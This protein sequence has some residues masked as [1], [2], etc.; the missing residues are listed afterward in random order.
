MPDSNFTLITDQKSIAF[1]LDNRK[2]SKIKNNKIHCWRLELALFSYTIKF[3]P[4]R[5]NDAADAFTHAVC[6]LVNTFTPQE[7]HQNLCH[8]GVRWLAHYVHAKNLPFL[9]EG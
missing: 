7:L 4:G 8:P 9:M 3:W 5:E 2:Q 6:T 1:M